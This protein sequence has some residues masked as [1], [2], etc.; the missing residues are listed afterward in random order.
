MFHLLIF[1]NH[2]YVKNQVTKHI[3]LQGR[4]RDGFDVF[5]SLQRF[6]CPS[7]N[8][9]SYNSIVNNYELWHK[10][11]AHASSR[12]VHLVMRLNNAN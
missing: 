1:P 3:I 10:R 9:T 4:I 6:L 2:C 8:A 12:T 7:L 5:L 11:L